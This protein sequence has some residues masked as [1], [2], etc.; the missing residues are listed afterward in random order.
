MDP[1]GP[2]WGP[3][4]DR[5]PGGEAQP[6]DGFAAPPGLYDSAIQ[7]CVIGDGVLIAHVGFLSGY[8]IQEGA[9]LLNIGSLEM[10]GESAF[11]QGTPIEVVNESGAGRC[12]STTVSPPKSPIC[13]SF[14]VT[15]AGLSNG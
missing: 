9:R 12:R 15:G 4:P 10:T 3:G 7:D 11:G 14:T 2:L 6:A 1:P 5:R 13:W 8:D